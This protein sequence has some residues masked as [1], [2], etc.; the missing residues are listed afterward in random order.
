MVSHIEMLSGEH[1]PL[2]PSRG[3]KQ[4][5]GDESKTK[6]HKSFSATFIIRDSPHKSSQQP[7]SGPIFCFAPIEFRLFTLLFF[8][9]KKCNHSQASLIQGI[10]TSYQKLF[11]AIDVFE[12]I[13]V[14]HSASDSGSAGILQASGSK[15]R[16]QILRFLG[17]INP[18]LLLGRQINSQLPCKNSIEYKIGQK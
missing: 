3:G 2:A 16:F 12:A 7:K 1:C 14:E 8:V 5:R 15:F 18:Y 4:Q 13:S 10:L 9:F 11:I 6:L 17:L